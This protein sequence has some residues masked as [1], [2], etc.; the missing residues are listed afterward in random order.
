MQAMAPGLSGDLH[1]GHSAGA[2][3]GGLASAGAGAGGL[4][5]AGAST[6]GGTGEAG[7]GAGAAGGREG[8]AAA[9]PAPTAASAAAGSPGTM[10][11]AWQDGQRNVLPAELSSTLIGLV[12]L[13]QRRTGMDSSL[14]SARRASEG[15]SLAGASG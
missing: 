4:L 5:A 7:R 10:N 9:A 1:A 12:H 2:C 3:A 6:A 13:G 14:G 15:R 11:G 8:L